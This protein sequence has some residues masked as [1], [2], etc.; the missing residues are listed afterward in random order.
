MRV[1]VTG[2][3]GF[4]GSHLC[5]ALLRRGDS[6]VCLDDFSTGEP[7]NIAH[8][9]SEPAFEFQHVDVSRFVE[10]DCRVDAVAHLA[11]P[12]S[13]PDYL[14]SAVGDPRGRQPGY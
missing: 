14:R 6:V 12:A 9:M 10:V 3:G 2:G 1:A 4:L 8:L 13:P 7:G 11:S 5:E